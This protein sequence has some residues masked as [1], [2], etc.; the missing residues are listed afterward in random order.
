VTGLLDVELE[1]HVLVVADAGGLD[2]LQDLANQPGHA[3]RVVQDALPL[4]AA[5]ADRLQPEPSSGD[6]CSRRSASRRSVSPSSSTVKRS[7]W[8]SVRGLQHLL[9][10]CLQRR[11]GVAQ[12]GHAQTVLARRARQRGGSRY[13]RSINRTVA[14]FRP[15]VTTWF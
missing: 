6:S 3:R 15:G 1:Q 12:L 5:A 2:L 7:T 10:Q 4:A 11:R 9:R 14:S 13:L 8:G